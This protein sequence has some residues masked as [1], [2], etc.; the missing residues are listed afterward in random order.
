MKTAFLMTTHD[1]SDDSLLIEVVEHGSQNTLHSVNVMKPS[2]RV[3]N[4]LDSPSYFKARRDVV[5]WCITNDVMLTNPPDFA[6]TVNDSREAQ[7]L[8][9]IDQKVAEKK[10][11]KRGAQ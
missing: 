3:G 11:A 2:L 6:K 5:K 7:I 1:H 9:K 10:A 8:A 4:R